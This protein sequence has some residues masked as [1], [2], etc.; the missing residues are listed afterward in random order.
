MKDLLEF[1]TDYLISSTGQ[2]TTTGLSRVLNNGIS[3]D[4][5]TRFLSEKDY[6]SK[7]LWQFVK[8]IYE[9]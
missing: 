2:V 5:I 6:D 4:K 9:R 1:Y 7:Y 3:H 8:N